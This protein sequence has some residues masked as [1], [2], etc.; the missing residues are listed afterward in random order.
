MTDTAPKTKK[1]KTTSKVA[2]PKKST[3]TK[4]TSTAKSS[5]TKSSTTKPSTK[6]TSTTKINS[7]ALDTKA[8]IDWQYI[9]HHSPLSI[10][11][12]DVPKQPRKRLI[13][14]YAFLIDDVT[15]FVMTSSIHL[16]NTPNDTDIQNTYNTLA[17]ELLARHEKALPNIPDTH[18]ALIQE[19]H[20]QKSDRYDDKNLPK[21]YFVGLSAVTA[22]IDN[23]DYV[24]NQQFNSE[25]FAH[26]SS[27]HD[28]STYLQLF[29]LQ[30]WQQ[31]LTQLL[32]P[33]DF[34]AFLKYHR[35]SIFNHHPFD[36][37]SNLA[38][39]FMHNA[40][41]FQRP[42]QV[43]KHLQKLDFMVRVTPEIKESVYKKQDSIEKLIARQQ[44]TSPLWVKAIERLVE[45]QSKIGMIDWWVIRQLFNQCGYT[46]M[47]IIEFVLSQ[48]TMGFGQKQEGAVIHE[49][50]YHRFGQHFSAVIYGLH[51][52]SE[53]HA[54]NIYRTHKSILNYID[55]QINDSE[56]QGLFLLGFDLSKTDEQGNIQVSM[57]VYYQ[58]SRHLK[59]Q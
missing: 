40:V 21:V 20:E 45:R 8:L 52:D 38:H 12:I 25:F 29:S 42:W 34:M 57:D 5:T 7:K 22:S 51:P 50:S 43:E 17:K 10:Y 11:Q 2:T 1:P 53:L 18:Q 24:L 13:Y 41:F 47:K 15:I 49:H 33:S 56:L 4:N 58:P 37:V 44:A 26:Y 3:R 36:T 19:T 14:D 28:E 46:R 59:A 54:N 23:T 35:H 48:R 55:E 39:E 31:L 30:E 27:N 16:D 32:S 9:I 6:K